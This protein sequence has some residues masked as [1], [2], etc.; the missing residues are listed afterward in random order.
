[1]NKEKNFELEANGL[2]VFVISI[3]AGLIN[4]LYQ[5][6]MGNMMAPQDYG[7]LNTLLSLSMVVSV[8]AGSIGV[9]ALK[10][11]SYFAANDSMDK[12]C[13]VFKRFV[14]IGLCCALATVAVG[15]A[16]TGFIKNILKID[17]SVYIIIALMVG[18]LEYI[19]YA[20]RGIL[21][22]LKKFIAY[23]MTSIVGAIGKIV[24]GVVLLL[25]GF[26]LYGVTFSLV[27]A[28][29]I[30]FVFAFV[31][32]KKY[33]LPLNRSSGKLDDI[34]LGGNFKYILCTQIF[35]LLMTNGDVLFI[36]MFTDN[37]TVGLYSS[38]SV[39]CKISYYF[40]NSIA[41]TLMPIVAQEY[42]KG[43]STFNL[44]IRSV[45]Y[46]VSVSAM[47][48]LAINIL[49]E[50]AITLL[51]GSEYISATNLL[52]PVSIFVIAL[53]LV[54]ILINYETAVNEMKLLTVTLIVGLIVT[55]ALVLGFHSTVAQ[56]M[57][58][59]A[60]GMLG[61]FTVNFIVIFV[62]NRKA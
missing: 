40:A 27:L 30:T 12:I 25:L 4:Y 16:A 62:K 51:F 15:A 52:I 55:V 31:C 19:L 54:T 20:G 53:N 18:A 28:S 10:Y 60:V 23:S 57:Y 2:I 36:K 32:L 49:G 38:V 7:L 61:I 47:C 35:L 8:P 29:V 21:Q 1:M 50:F 22:G 5:I 45:I 41:C 24:I 9:I 6:I 14:T 3:A 48:A 42:E 59:L 44:F 33:V 58:S 46:G 39:L 13:L 11:T 34:N 37:H 56:I 43:K 26:G 17:S